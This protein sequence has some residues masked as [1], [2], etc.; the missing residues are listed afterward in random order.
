[1]AVR[2]EYSPVNGGL[3]MK[4]AMLPSSSTA[5]CNTQDAKNRRN[6]VLHRQKRLKT[7]SSSMYKLIMHASIWYCSVSMISDLVHTMF[8]QIKS[9][10]ILTVVVSSSV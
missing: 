4:L 1:M 7:P 2:S 10:F 8:T 5:L 9:E 6:A 3:P